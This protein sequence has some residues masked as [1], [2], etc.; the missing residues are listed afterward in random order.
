MLP[1][2]YSLNDYQIVTH[3]GEGHFSHV[4]LAQEVKSGNLDA[5]KVCKPAISPDDLS[6]FYRENEIL[7]QLKSH[8]RVVEPRTVVLT[9]DQYVY[10]S[11]EKL[12]SDLGKYLLTGP[13]LDTNGKIKL[14]KGV[15]EGLKHAHDRGVAHRDLWWDNILIKIEPIQN[16]GEPKLTDFGR[17]KNFS[18]ITGFN[19]GSV[20]GAFL[21][22]VPPEKH[23][24]IYDASD[25]S[26][27]FLADI[28][29]LGIVL[30]YIMEVSPSYHATQL[31][32]NIRNFAIRRK[33]AC[34]PATM[35]ERVALYQ[36]WLNALTAPAVD[37]LAISS[38]PE[39]DLS[40]KI[41]SVVSKMSHP[42]RDKRYANL[43]ELITELAQL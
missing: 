20:V 26:G 38:I 13:I 3:L 17:S 29:A 7:H 8:P 6:R 19:S 21:Y 16:V 27:D 2:G 39:K 11:M 41:N 42:D 12:D 36:E 25:P 1:D 43:E 37:L 31:L 28:Y 32:D 22:I 34:L 24:G 30:Y 35:I 4:F 40:D 33:L 10:Y 5:V 14:F 9:K 23:F 15:V 18:V